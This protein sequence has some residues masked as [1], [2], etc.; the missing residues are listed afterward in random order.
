MKAFASAVLITVVIAVIAVTVFVIYNFFGMYRHN[1]GML[2]NNPNTF[3]NPTS[4]NASIV[5]FTSSPRRME[6]LEMILP[7]GVM[8]NQHI[9]PADHQY[10]YTHVWTANPSPSDL[11]DVLVPADGFV[12]S[13]Q[14]MPSWTFYASKGLADY[15][16]VIDH[17]CNFH[18]IYIHLLNISDKIKS[19]EGDLS[20]S[21]SVPVH[22]P[23]KAGEVL[24]GA[25]SLD[26]SAY[27]DNVMLKGFVTPSDYNGEPWKVHTV[28][29]F[30][31]FVEPRRSQLIAKTERAAAPYGGKIDYDI[32]GRLIGGWFVENSGGYAGSLGYNS[33]STHLAIVYDA[34]DPSHIIFSIG[35]FTTP[36]DGKQFGLKGNSPDPATIDKNSGIL[37]LELVTYNYI[38]SAG[39]AWDNFHYASGLKAVNHDDQVQGVA[40]L[41]LVSDRRLEVQVFPGQTAS[42]VSGF[43]NPT[44]YVR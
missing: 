40:L 25:V 22:V 39:I 30:D 19:A 14:R 31:Y 15:R 10:Y 3:Y 20:Q 26:F 9:I 23:V 37:K 18:T 16:L 4:C 7:M 41:Q 28:D 32:D 2:Y 12:S 42:S 1:S 27:D 44:F 38:S 29:P 6:D 5:N 36:G 43:T 13:V 34:I 24:G 35:T 11:R 17:S 21:Q 8:S 33:W